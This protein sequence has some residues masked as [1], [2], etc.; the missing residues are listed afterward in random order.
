[1]AVGALF[2]ATTDHFSSLGFTSLKDLRMQSLYQSS[3]SRIP[4]NLLEIVDFVF[5]DGMRIVASCSGPSEVFSK[6]R[7]KERYAVF[8]KIWAA[9]D[10]GRSK[11]KQYIVFSVWLT[12][13]PPLISLSLAFI[14]MFSIWSVYCSLRSLYGLAFLNTWENMKNVLHFLIVSGLENRKMLQISGGLPINVCH[15]GTIRQ[16]QDLLCRQEIG[17]VFC[18]ERL[19]RVEEEA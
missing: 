15:P 8:C 7:S 12:Q 13:F 1:M 11:Q 19:L 2:G 4:H 5:R 18:K 9:L 16:A 3:W 14:K 6:G 17:V 10:R